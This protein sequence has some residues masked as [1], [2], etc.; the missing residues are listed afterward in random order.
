MKSTLALLPLILVTAC[1]NAAGGSVN[2]TPIA[3]IPDRVLSCMLGHALNLDPTREQRM[4]EIKYEGQFAFELLLPNIAPRQT[5]PPDATD[6]AEPVDPRTQ[7]LADPA[8][9]RKGVPA[10][11]DRVIDLWPERVEMTRVIEGA[12][13]HLIIINQIDSQRGTANLFMTTATDV[14]TMDLKNVYQGPC[15]VTIGAAAKLQ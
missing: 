4:D 1:G 15:R 14:A 8:G 12:H 7:V 6:P 2:Q 9:L 13:T 5:P 10:G 11:F 3:R